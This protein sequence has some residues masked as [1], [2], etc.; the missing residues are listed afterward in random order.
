MTTVATAHVEG[1][2]NVE[3]AIMGDLRAVRGE[4]ERIGREA[5]EMSLRAEQSASA[6]GAITA[7]A[8]LGA[9]QGLL[10]Q[11]PAEVRTEFLSNAEEATISVRGYIDVIDQTPRDWDTT[12]DDN[13]DA[14]KARIQTLI[15]KI[16][17]V[18]TTRTITFRIRTVGAIPRQ[19]GGMVRSAET[20]LV[21]EAGPE[22][23]KL[24][25]GSRVIPAGPTRALLAGHG[26]SRPTAG[27]LTHLTINVPLALDGHEVGFSS[28]SGV[29]EAARAEGFFEEAT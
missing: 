21:G 5:L 1:S 11:V 26:G 10:A 6:L 15:N 22:L 13:T 12:F 8:Q 4:L 16:N 23:V 3:Q 9:L 19:H 28:W 27:G 17:A 20:T 29:L 24:P 7:E 14:A 25:A 2:S 18:P